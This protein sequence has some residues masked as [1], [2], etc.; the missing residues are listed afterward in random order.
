MANT[1]SPDSVYVDWKAF[2]VSACQP[3]ARPT[4][5]NLLQALNDYKDIDQ[6]ET[7]YVTRE[8]FNQVR[9]HVVCDSNLT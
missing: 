7:G 9:S 8:Q 5:S 4:Q 2:L 1:L 6:E 3:L